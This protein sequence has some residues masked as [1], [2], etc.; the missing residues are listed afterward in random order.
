MAEAEAPPPVAIP[1]TPAHIGGERFWTEVKE[2]VAK[3]AN[4]S[5]T[6]SD[7]EPRPFTPMYTISIMEARMKCVY[8]KYWKFVGEGFFHGSFNFFVDRL[9]A[10]REL[11]VNREEFASAIYAYLARARE[12]MRD[13]ANWHSAHIPPMFPNMFVR[14]LVFRVRELVAAGT[15]SGTAETDSDHLSPSSQ[16]GEDD[17]IRVLSLGD[18]HGSYGCLLN[19]ILQLRDEGAISDDWRLLDRRTH[20]VFTG[21]FADRGFFG[22]EIWLTILYLMAMNPTRVFTIKANH[23]FGAETDFRHRE[24]PA[25]LGLPHKLFPHIMWTISRTFPDMLFVGARVSFN[26]SLIRIT[27]PS[28]SVLDA[29]TAKKSRFSPSLSKRKTEQQAAPPEVSASSTPRYLPAQSSVTSIED[30]VVGA[31]LA[32]LDAHTQ[33]VHAP[34]SAPTAEHMTGVADPLDGHVHGNA[35][36]APIPAIFVEE[37][38]ASVDGTNLVHSH[39]DHTHHDEGVDEDDCDGVPGSM[40]GSLSASG[41][42]G[43]STSLASI[44]R[45]Q[46]VDH[47]VVRYV[48]YSHGAMEPGYVPHGFLHAPI[49]SMGD[50]G[51]KLHLVESYD[52]RPLLAHLDA[53]WPDAGI[54]MRAHREFAEI[55]LVVHS[56]PDEA[57]GAGPVWNTYQNGNWLDATLR[58]GQMGHGV[59][60]GPIVVRCLLEMWANDPNAKTVVLGGAQ[61]PASPKP[62]WIRRAASKAAK[63]LSILRSVGGSVGRSGSIDHPCIYF[64]KPYHVEF[65]MNVGGH[66]HGKGIGVNFLADARAYGG[67]AVLDCCR[68]DDVTEHDR[69]QAAGLGGSDASGPTHTGTNTGRAEKAFGDRKDGGLHSGSDSGHV[70]PANH[71]LHSVGTGSHTGDFVIHKYFNM[72]DLVYYKLPTVSCGRVVMTPRQDGVFP[73]MHTDPIKDI[74][75]FYG[76]PAAAALRAFQ[77]K[78]GARDSEDKM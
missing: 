5:G 45:P 14:K 3:F 63:T 15:S 16:Y 29:P 26:P 35:N 52:R 37:D 70:H 39:S 19:V 66:E 55:P 33:T 75:G 28:S 57:C 34:Q 49:S 43:S 25:K 77:E 67:H 47:S 78:F 41:D 65:A 2:R 64:R 76:E 58:L 36:N 42:K 60:L 11:T 51:P 68:L 73:V 71:D 38:E 40:F 17:D 9:D 69:K 20:L 56:T 46:R 6:S 44:G 54:R 48:V 23:E 32:A 31:R 53:K 10:S 24:A 61:D 27:P 72:W 30:F 50:S 59:C 13:P 4:L 18:M 74:A 12:L 1:E 8:D 22:V 7:L 62:S 21:D